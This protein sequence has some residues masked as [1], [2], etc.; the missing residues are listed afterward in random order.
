MTL[1]TMASAVRVTSVNRFIMYY[2][3]L[4]FIFLLFID[5][6]LA[7]VVRLTSVNM[8]PTKAMA[9]ENHPTDTTAR[10]H[11]SPENCD[12]IVLKSYISPFNLV[13]LLLDLDPRTSLGCD[14]MPP[15]GKSESTDVG[16]RRLLS[17]VPFHDRPN[18]LTWS[19]MMMRNRKSKQE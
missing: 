2:L 10:R 11:P 7:L 17:Q 9:K 18:R 14:M 19:S 16:D 15:G 4:S 12:F 8:K 6:S 1:M 13:W 3:Y 5:L